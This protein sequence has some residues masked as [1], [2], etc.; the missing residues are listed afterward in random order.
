MSRTYRHITK[1]GKKN[2]YARKMYMKWFDRQDYYDSKK[3]ML[4]NFLMQYHREGYV[5]N[6]PKV[7]RDLMNKS[8]KISDKQK[9]IT[10]LKN[11]TFDNMPSFKWHKDANYIYF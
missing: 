7:F 4:D 11:D 5:Q 8:K 6:A 10:H 2:A 1:D 9:L 3:E